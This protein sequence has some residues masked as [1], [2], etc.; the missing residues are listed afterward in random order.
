[1]LKIF[2]D[3]PPVKNVIAGQNATLDLD[4]GYNYH[5]IRLIATVTK[6]NATALEPTLDEAIGQ[7]VLNVN[8]VRNARIYWRAI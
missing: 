2:R 3:A 7:I 5:C 4:L 6:D 8:K 1:M